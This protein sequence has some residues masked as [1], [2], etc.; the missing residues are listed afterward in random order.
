MILAI[1]DVPPSVLPV[2]ITSPAPMPIIAP[3]NTELIT[4]SSM[5][6][7]IFSVTLKKNESAVFEMTV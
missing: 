7:L 3:P 1:T 6:K 2:E 4:K 5:P